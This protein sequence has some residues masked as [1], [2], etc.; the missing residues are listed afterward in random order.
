[1]VCLADKLISGRQRCTVTERFA[2]SEEKYRDDAAVL[3]LLQAR[4]EV[5]LRL[6]R[7]V[8]ALLGT[9]C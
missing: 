2:R 8:E 7:N 6:E 5:A 1:M 4:R 9:S 3:A